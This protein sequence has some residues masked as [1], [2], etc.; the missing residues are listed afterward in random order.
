VL[1]V[2]AIH[3][4]ISEIRFM[5]SGYQSDLCKKLKDGSGVHT[6]DSPTLIA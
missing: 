2:S 6:Y 1:T 3:G 5:E 4:G